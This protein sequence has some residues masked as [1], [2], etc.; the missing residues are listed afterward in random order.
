MGKLDII[1]NLLHATTGGYAAPHIFSCF[2][3]GDE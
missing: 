1:D 3:I 2:L